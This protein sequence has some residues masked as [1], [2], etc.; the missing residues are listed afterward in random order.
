MGQLIKKLDAS[1]SVFF[2]RQLEAIDRR[3]FDQKY[4]ALKARQLIPTVPG[5][6]D[7]ANVYTW[8]EFDKYGKA[9]VI[10]NM[11]D[12]LP[13]ADAKGTENS[14]VI[15]TLGSAYGYDV[16]EI[17]RAAATQTPLEQ[18][19]AAA[20][21]F[22]IE[23]EIDDILATGLSTHNL[24]GIL[25]LS[26]TLTFTPATK[27]AG[28][29]EWSVATPDEIVSD[30]TGIANYIVEQTKGVFSRFVVVLPIEQ[31][32]IIATKRMGDGSDSTILKFVLGVSPFIEAIEP[33]FKCDAAGAGSA[34]RM[35]CYPR[36][37]MVLGGIVPME[38]T[39]LEPEKRNLEYVIDCIASCGGVVC[40]YPVA[41]AYGD[42]I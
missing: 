21:R 32:N 6:P 42:G 5:I 34:D 3:A 22:A 40:R 11:A 24:Q 18:M 14:K 13:R 23:Q 16:M 31:Y 15:K 10:A 28:G 41:V 29:T 1:E 37:E 26:N 27:A 7:W 4:A 8:R 30:L 19:K 20:A 39:P 17:K 25:N 38:F 9:K 35:V 2:K 33:W 12:D 36:D